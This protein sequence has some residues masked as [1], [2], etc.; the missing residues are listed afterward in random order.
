MISLCHRTVFVHIPKCAGQSVEAAF[1]SDLGL[2]WQQH[3]YLLGCFERPK[4]WPR[5]L[6]DRLAHLTAHEIVARNMLPQALFTAFYRFAIVR[7]PVAR[8][9]SMWRFLAPDSGFD[10]FVQQDLPR[11][12]CEGHFWYRS[13]RAYL[14]HPD[15]GALLVD[16]VIPFSRIAEHWPEVMR[17]A[18]LN[19]PLGHRNAA[20]AGSELPGCASDTEAAIRE[21]YAEDYQSFGA[22]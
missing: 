19:V 9:V 15:T 20:P 12:V 14:C 3:R 6:P 13:Q 22:F 1:C 16:H 11:R 17:R 10:D 2:K 5:G 18:G 21:I 4:G 8:V 7:D